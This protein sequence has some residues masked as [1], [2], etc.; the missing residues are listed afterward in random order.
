MQDQIKICVNLDLDYPIRRYQELYSGIQK[1]ARQNNWT[2][3]PDHYPEGIIREKKCAYYDG[4]IGRIKH[5]SYE[6]A[7]HYAIPVVNTWYNNDIKDI[8]S[9][10]VDLKKCGVLAATHL[11]K[12]GFWNIAL[13]D[14]PLEKGAKAFYE[15]VQEAVST[16]GGQ[17][18]VYPLCRTFNTSLDKWMES[19]RQLKSWCNEWEPPMGIVTSQC[20]RIPQ[21]ISQ[22]AVHGFRIPKDVAFVV[23]DYEPSTCEGS[24]P[25]ISAVNIDHVK[26]GYE[27]ARVLDMKMH[28]REPAQKVTLVECHSFTARESSDMYVFK[29]VLLKKSLRFIADNFREGIQVADVANHLGCSRRSLERRFLTYIGRGVADEINQLRVEGLKKLLME[30]DQKINLLA[31]Q[32]G[33]SSPASMGRVFLRYEGLTPSE[34]RMSCKRVD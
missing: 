31:V 19:K 2:L 3:I 11:I 14:D 4:M 27:A 17:L 32:S 20:G 33:F 10:L 6:E 22:C 12:R 13:L 7:K 23:G 34:Y 18:K 29:D 16:T 9:V 24:F 30:S 15:G 1:Y 21:I 8:T 28:G 25:T 26:L 5:A